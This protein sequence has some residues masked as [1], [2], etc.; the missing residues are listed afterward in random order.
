MCYDG[1]PDIVPRGFWPMHV[2]GL[3]GLAA[4]M[5]GQP[6]VRRMEPIG[7]LAH[8]AI[9]EASGIV[10]SRRFPGIFWTHNDSGNPPAL[11]AVRPDGSEDS[12]Y[13]VGAPNV[14]WEDIPLDAA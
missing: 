6:S 1:R 14:D 12:E 10:Q 8:P 3:V 7:R 9:R 11:F 5:I 2:I 13:S 4:L